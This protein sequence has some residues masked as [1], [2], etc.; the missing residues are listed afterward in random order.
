MNIDNTLAAQ[1]DAQTSPLILVID[2]DLAVRE[3]LVAVMEAF[4]FRTHTAEN[5]LKGLQAVARETPSAII[6]D[7]NMPE[8]DGFALMSALRAA[9]N[10]IPVIAISGASS[11]GSDSLATAKDLGAAAIF[12]KPLPVLA[13]ID[14]INDLTAHH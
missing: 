10:G 6:T 9:S 11:T 7:L 12:H 4:G 1:R 3:S 13:L 8:M 2:D 14:R 5:G